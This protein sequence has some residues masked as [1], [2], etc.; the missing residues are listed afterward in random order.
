L[1]IAAAVWSVLHPQAGFREPEQL[2][3]NGILQI[4]RPY[5]GQMVSVLSIA[6]NRDLLVQVGVNKPTILNR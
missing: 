3:H 5:L 6:T 2:P 1:T 4:S